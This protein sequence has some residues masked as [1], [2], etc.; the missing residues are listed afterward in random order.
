M[1]TNRHDSRS[2]V[3]ATQRRKVRLAEE[4]AARGSRVGGS[5]EKSTATC[6]VSNAPHVQG[7]G[8][9]L[10]AGDEH[11]VRTENRQTPRKA[12][13]PAA[14]QR[15]ALSPACRPLRTGGAI[16]SMRT[17]TTIRN[18]TRNTAIGRALTQIGAEHAAL[19]TRSVRQGRASYFAGPSARQDVTRRRGSVAVVDDA[20]N[21]T[22]HG[23]HGK[24]ERELDLEEPSPRRPA[25][26]HDGC[27][28]DVPAESTRVPRARS[29]VA[30]GKMRH[31]LHVMIDREQR[32]APGFSEPNTASRGRQARPP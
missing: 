24:Q 25:A 12:Q 2:S 14:Y 18:G 5:F 15:Y 1:I 7:R 31:A 17:A 19:G 4:Q 6:R 20:E 23:D 9:C 3:L 22:R 8:L 26:V 11:P 28:D 29:T 16:R 27:L 10:N 21:K 30:N 32:R 13:G